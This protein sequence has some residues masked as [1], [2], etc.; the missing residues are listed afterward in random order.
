[1]AVGALGS[2]RA[3]KAREETA[4]AGRAAITLI[5]TGAALFAALTGFMGRVA[6][7][8]DVSPL[9]ITLRPFLQPGDKI[10]QFK[11]FQ[12]SA[13]YYT[14]APS[15]IV[16]FVNTSGLEEGEFKSSPYFPKDQ[17]VLRELFKSPHHVYVLVRWKHA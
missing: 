16:D 6:P 5:A 17:K 11:T 8:E 1:L 4:F 9:L 3:L 14:G 10:I 13:M 15:T 7:Y 12:P 2:W